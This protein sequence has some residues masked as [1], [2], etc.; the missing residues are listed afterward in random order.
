MKIDEAWNYPAVADIDDPGAAAGAALEPGAQALHP[1]VPKKHVRLRI[2][3]A[4][5]ID[6]PA[7][8]EADGGHEVAMEYGPRVPPVKD[9]RADASALPAWDG[10]DSRQ[11]D[12]QMRLPRS[13][14]TLLFAVAS[15][16]AV[17]C[18]HGDAAPPATSTAVSAER[19]TTI[20][21]AGGTG[22]R[23]A[24]KTA[25][26]AC[27]GKW[28]RHGL[29]EVESCICKTKDGGKACT[30]GND[31]QAHCVAKDADFV[32]V[33]K[34]P[35]AKGHWKG[36]CSEYD[37]VFGCYRFVPKGASKKPPQLADDAA[38]QLCYD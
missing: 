7:A 35:P 27:G 25:C 29:A 37:T 17:S 1:A 34:G 22:D 9:V 36:K 10:R 28:A 18:K 14:V 12:P 32:V 31:C 33:Q 8:A 15:L 21:G 20:A 2:E 19:S 4:G 38:D 23:P 30:D 5:R 11:Y 3:V 24:S 6:H 16:A 26:D 13:L